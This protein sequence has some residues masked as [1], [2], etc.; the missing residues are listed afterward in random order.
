MNRGLCV[1]IL[2]ALLPQVRAQQAAVRPATRVDRGISISAERRSVMATVRS[3][4]LDLAYPG[5]KQGV[6]YISILYDPSNQSYFWLHSPM[7]PGRVASQ[8]R[9]H[10]ESPAVFSNRWTPF[11]TP[12]GITLFNIGGSTISV[13]E[14]SSTEKASTLA[15][16]EE[17]VLIRIRQIGARMPITAVD[18]TRDQFRVVGLESALGVRFLAAP[19]S[20]ILTKLR[21]ISVSKLEVGWELVVQCEWKERLILGED[22]RLVSHQRIQ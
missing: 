16:A 22:Y 15:E 14:S 13:I 20:P 17:K 10:T 7:T 11:S 2:L 18:R 19:F 9:P 3:F 21:L 12:K 6:G 4:D 1:A 8:A 5:G